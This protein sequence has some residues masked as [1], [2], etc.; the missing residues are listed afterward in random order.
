MSWRD[1]DMPH[2]GDV[3]ISVERAAL[4]NMNLLQRNRFADSWIAAFI[5][6]DHIEEQ[7]RIARGRRTS[8]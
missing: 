5:R 6:Y 8:G 1:A 2:G 3:I 4:T 7:D